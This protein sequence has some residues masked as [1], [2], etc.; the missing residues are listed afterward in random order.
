MTTM[1]RH[2]GWFRGKE[3]R[4]LDG[5]LFKYRALLIASASCHIKN[6]CL[7]YSYIEHPLILLH[8]FWNVS[9]AKLRASY[10]RILSFQIEHYTSVMLFIGSIALVYSN[11][12]IPKRK[13]L[14]PD[15]LLIVWSWRLDL[16]DREEFRSY[17]KVDVLELIIN[18][19][20]GDMLNISLFVALSSVSWFPSLSPYIM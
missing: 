18:T 16:S 7:S 2:L 5:F 1:L 6:G 10:A 11:T 17:W 12:H 19:K 3:S 13:L 15:N 20:S 9:Y 4:I 8:M 14:A